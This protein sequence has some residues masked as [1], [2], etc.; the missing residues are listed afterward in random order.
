MTHPEEAL[1]EIGPMTP[2]IYQVLSRR[3]DLADTFT[4]ELTPVNEAQPPPDPGQFNMLWAFGVGEAPISVAGYEGGVL[5]HTIRQVGAVTRSL[6]AAGEGDQIG[7]RGPYGTGWGLARAHGGDAVVVAGGLGLA[8]VRPIITSVMRDRSLYGRVVVL[9]GARTPDYLLYRE[10]LEQWSNRLDIEIQLTV[11]VAS[12][13]WGGNVGMV[14]RLIGRADFNPEVTTAFVCGPEVMMRFVA[15]GLI[16]R[17]V[18]PAN[19]FVS[20]ERNMHCAIG[21]CGHCQLGPEFICKDGPV[22]PWPRVEPLLRTRE[23]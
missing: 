22:L 13:D 4:L 21:H 7:L 10:E 12:R 2:H 19:V 17:G 23:R 1:A 20:L 15:R 14:T 5:T 11:D 16:D 9:V 6:C 8:P 3:Q 18:R